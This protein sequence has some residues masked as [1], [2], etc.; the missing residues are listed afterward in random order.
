MFQTPFFIFANLVKKIFW[1][2]TLDKLLFVMRYVFRPRKQNW[3]R[4]R[5]RRDG[6]QPQRV[7]GSQ[8]K[9]LA[10]RSLRDCRHKKRPKGLLEQVAGIEPATTAWEADVFPLNY[11]CIT[12][13]LAQRFC[14]V[15]NFR[16][17]IV[18]IYKI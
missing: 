18:L 2:S 10:R 4:W 13:M 9:S 7:A 6:R 1:A 5:T 16:L 14:F 3:L 17:W 8:A 11:T 15:K 12:F